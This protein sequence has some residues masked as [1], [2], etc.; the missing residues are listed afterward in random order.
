MG[1]I[2]RATLPEEFFDTTSATMLKQPEPQYFYGLLLKR[3]LG[4]SLANL[5]VGGL[6]LPGHEIATEGADYPGAEEQ[7]LELERDI[8]SSNAI[9]VV[10]ELGKG[11]GDTVRLNRPKFSDTTYT[12][13]SRRIL[14]NATISVTPISVQSEQVSLT[15]DRFGGPYDSTNNCV[16]PIGIDQYTAKLPV[17]Q[18]IQVRGTHLVRDFDKSVDSWMVTLFDLAANAIYGGNATA[19]TDYIA[20]NDH[21]FDLDMVRRAGQKLTELHIP[22]FPDGKW[23]MSLTPKQIA[24]LGADPEYQRMTR[25]DLSK[26]GLNSVYSTTYYDTVGDFNIFKNATLNTSATGSGGAT[27]HYGH[28]FGPGMIGAG[29]GDMP[30][31]RQSTT[32]NYGTTS[33]VIWMWIAAFSALDSRFCLSMRS[34]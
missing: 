12:M 20:A 2:T 13:A 5:N 27:V 29:M 26:T 19:I 25:F 15:L 18:L 34:D 24:D 33:L 6:P 21:R 28:A 4:L 11:P 1:N 31:A 16:A 8:I 14:P 3:A 9:I 30:E 10:P 32:T 22:R 7:R 23:I 17:H